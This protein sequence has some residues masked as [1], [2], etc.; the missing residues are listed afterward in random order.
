LEESFLLLVNIEELC[1]LHSFANS[2]KYIHDKTTC[3]VVLGKSLLDANA[4]MGYIPD[5]VDLVYWHDLLLEITSYAISSVKLEY[6]KQLDIWSMTWSKLRE[7]AL[8]KL[9]RDLQRRLDWVSAKWVVLKKRKLRWVP[10]T[11]DVPER[12]FSFFKLLLTSTSIVKDS[13][14]WN[15]FWFMKLS[16]SLV[17]NIHHF[18]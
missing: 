2:S 10:S 17:V 9:N 5:W 15:L 18:W 8:L 7:D 6:H 4:L 1:L 13:W 11:W 3:A 14:S 16:Y 12:P